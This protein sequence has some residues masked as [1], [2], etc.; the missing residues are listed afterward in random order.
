MGSGAI[1]QNADPYA[2]TYS[3]NGNTGGTA[4]TDGNTYSRVEF[5]TASENTGNL[6]KTGYLFAGW[7]TAA[8]GSGMNYAPGNMFKM[9][10]NLTLYAQWKADPRHRVTYNGNGS[11]VGTVPTDDAMYWERDAV[12]VAGNTGNLAKSRVRFR[13]L[14]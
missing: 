3:G 9:T 8:D 10:S 12:T 11:T 5:V 14:E 6:S 13:G 4:P 2:L 1:L 7:N